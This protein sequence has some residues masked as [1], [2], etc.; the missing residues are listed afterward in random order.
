M[1]KIKTE[2]CSGAINCTESTVE[3]GRRM[4]QLHRNKNTSKVSGGA[5]GDG[6]TQVKGERGHGK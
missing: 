2:K 6:R 1:P 4:A 5:G 3:R